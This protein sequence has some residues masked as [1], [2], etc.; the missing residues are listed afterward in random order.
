MTRPALITAAL[1]VLLAGC[2]S[3][4]PPVVAPA[5]APAVSSAPVPARPSAVSAEARGLYRTTEACKAPPTR[6]ELDVIDSAKTLLGQPPN[7][8]VLVNG[9][10]FVL[11]CIGTV[12]AIYY[13]LWL[14]LTKDFALYPGN[15][16][17]RLY[18]TLEAQR[19]L[20]GDRYPRPG[21]IVFWDNT[22]DANDNG[23]RTDDLKTHAG[24][25][26][27]VDDDGTI[28]YVHEN[29]YKG[30][31]I[32]AMNLL[33]PDDARDE[34]GKLLNS[35]MAIATASGGPRPTHWL[36]G[37]VFSRFGD[38]LRVKGHFAVEHAEAPA[39]PA[40]MMAMTAAVEPREV[41]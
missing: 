30:V 25:V 2:A 5:P 12:S 38:A 9:K 34:S 11:D 8:K 36:S 39:M 14:D 1:S 15:G 35:G 40:A 21:D 17:N 18:R 7:A 13:K 23:D 33:R 28:H 41:K 37:D 19:V 4:P 3:A 26:L 31:V 27:A 24:I 29:L 10:R 6:D 16:V 32:E 20:H 22:W